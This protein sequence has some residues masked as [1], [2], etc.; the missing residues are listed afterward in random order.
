M[1][2]HKRKGRDMK[3]NW[4][5]PTGAGH[6]FRDDWLDLLNKYVGTLD[7]SEMLAL[8]AYSVGQMLAM[9]DAR[10]WTPEMAM[11]VIARNIEAGNAQ[12]IAEA[13]KWMGQA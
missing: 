6:A 2:R 12:A 11:E 5:E 3:T 10:K 4:K 1:G 7:A 8:A 13:S 9:Q